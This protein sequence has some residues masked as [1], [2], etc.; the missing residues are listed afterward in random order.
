MMD[1]INVNKFYWRYPT[2][3]GSVNEFALKG[4][5]LQIKENEFFGITGPSGSGKTTLCFAISGLIPHQVH[6]SYEDA[7]QFMDG[8]IK[9]FGDTVSA[10]VRKNGKNIIMGK[11]TMAPTVG[12]VM[13]DPESQFLTMSVKQELSLG[14]QFM[15]LHPAE[16]DA[17]IKEALRRVGMYDLYADSERIHPAELSGGQKQRLII[18]SFIAMQPKI[19]I[20]DEPT[21]DLDP[22]GKM[23]VIDAIERIKEE[24]KLTVILVEHNPEIMQ[25]FADRIAVMDKGRIAAVGTPEKIY[26][27][28]RLVKKHSIYAPELADVRMGKGTRAYMTIESFVAHAR[29]LKIKDERLPQ[30]PLEAEAI[31]EPP[32]ELISVKDLNFSYGD[33]THALD[34]ISFKIA[35]GEFVALVGQNGS[36]KSTLSKVISGI[37][38]S[39]KGNVNVMGMDLHAAKN[40]ALMPFKVGYIFQNPDHQIFNRSVYSEVA[41]GLKNMA[42]PTKEMDIR[43]K[44]ALKNVGLESKAS[45]DPLFLGKGQK[46][47]LAV[48]SVLAMEPEILIVDEPTTGQDYTM[49]KEIMELL[50]GMNGDG[51]TIFVITHDMRLVAE[52]CKRSIVMNA[53]GIIYDGSTVNLFEDDALLS[54]ASLVAPQSVKLSK[55][56][57]KIGMLNNILLTASDLNDFFS[58]SG[59]KTKYKR[60]DFDAMRM[61]AKSI[62]SAIKSKHGAPGAIVYVQRGGMVFGR[63]LSDYLGVSKVYGIK[64]SYYN[65]YGLPS[66]GVYVGNP[67]SMPENNGYVL[68]VD[69]IIDTGKTMAAVSSKLLTVSRRLVTVALLCKEGSSF[70]PDF[71]GAPAGKDSWII[72]DYEKEETYRSFKHDNNHAGMKFI[73]ENFG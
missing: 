47:R 6:L 5:N 69:D 18:A 30:S 48:A 35:K 54:K 73:K 53:G 67:R 55:E 9:V 25:R 37:E 59:L 34:S 64:A 42:M 61:H 49:A 71:C 63:L 1:A 65:E 4:I 43:V 46:R 28:K 70:R 29:L 3:T 36:G 38:S 14:L 72:F 12:I 50:K 58:F 21:S 17:R 20:L 66:K 56:L 62:A 51:K 10:V 2:F 22:A 40:R 23:E 8:S 45:E 44:K 19:L 33:G 31:R 32:R 15:G 27:D 41:Y 52:Y 7:K 16:I 26:S 11:G 57:K 24:H 13:Q 39:F 68:L 60:M